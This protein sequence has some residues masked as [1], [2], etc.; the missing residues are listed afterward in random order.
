MSTG[1]FAKSEVKKVEEILYS[2]KDFVDVMELLEPSISSS[3]EEVPTFS[4]EV[5]SG[6]EDVVLRRMQF[7]E[8]IQIIRSKKEDL[9]PMQQ[10]LLELKYFFFW[11]N[12]EIWEELKI[13]SSKFYCIRKE[14]ILFFAN[15]FDIDV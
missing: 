14:V 3:F 5:Y 15:V 12:Y 1:W 11:N 10:R 8:Y 4:N 7:P 9:F 6:T 13:N 2:Y